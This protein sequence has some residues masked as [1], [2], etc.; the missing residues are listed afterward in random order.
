MLISSTQFNPAA[1]EN[2][3]HIPEGIYLQKGEEEKNETPA[4]EEPSE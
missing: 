3:N 2:G 1:G 4:P